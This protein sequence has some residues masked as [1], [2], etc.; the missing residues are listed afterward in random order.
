MNNWGK[1]P[2]AQHRHGADGSTEFAEVA[3]DELLYEP[4]PGMTWNHEI[5]DVTPLQTFGNGSVLLGRLDRLLPLS[6]GTAENRSVVGWLPGNASQ[7]LDGMAA[8]GDKFTGQRAWVTQKK[9]PRDLWRALL[10]HQVGHTYGL[11]NNTATTGGYHW[12]DV[13]ERSIKRVLL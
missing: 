2:A 6:N 12:F 13:Y 11:S 1:G 4:M 7:Q 8:E 3:D 9:A 10:A 5:D